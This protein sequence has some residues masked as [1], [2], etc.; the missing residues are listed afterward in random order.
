MAY[1]ELWVSAHGYFNDMK[2]N[3]KEVAK[4]SIY[5]VQ[6][7]GDGCVLIKLNKSSRSV[8][9]SFTAPTFLIKQ[10]QMQAVYVNF[11]CKSL[12]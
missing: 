1:C 3:T 5:Y 4:V 8:V 11:K 6:K 2:E 12:V 9:A 7:L 10:L